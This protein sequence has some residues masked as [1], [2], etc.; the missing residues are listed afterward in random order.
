VIRLGLND[1]RTLEVPED[2]SVTG[3]SSGGYA[4]AMRATSQRPRYVTSAR[5]LGW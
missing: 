1:D 3:W 5:Q 2:Y 4:H